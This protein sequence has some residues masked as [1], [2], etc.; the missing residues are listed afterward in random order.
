MSKSSSAPVAV[1]ALLALTFV[2]CASRHQ[3]GVKSDYRSQ[4]TSVA[5]DT[6]ATTDAARTVLERRELKDI[7]AD[8][9]AVDGVAKAKMADGT[10]VT[11]DVKREGDAASRVSVTVGKLGDP[12]LGADL[13]KQIKTEAEGR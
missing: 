3:S 1:L 11:V 5:A 2:G 12:K 13:A 10:K 8:S 6:K 9:T 4:W 7:T